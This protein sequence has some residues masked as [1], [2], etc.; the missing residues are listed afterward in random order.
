MLG[1]F[2]RLVSMA[3]ASYYDLVLAVIPSVFVLAVLVGHL[4]SVPAR[5]AIAAAA[6]VAAVAL[7]DALFVNPPTA[8]SS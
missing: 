6:A 7:V 3:Q 2:E 8:G 4:L 1:P 5:T